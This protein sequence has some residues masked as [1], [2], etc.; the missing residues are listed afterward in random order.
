M[1]I[2]WPFKSLRFRISNDTILKNEGRLQIISYRN[3]TFNE[4]TIKYGAPQRSALGPLL[5]LIYINDLPSFMSKIHTISFAD[6]NT[7]L[8]LYCFIHPININVAQSKP[9][10]WFNVNYL[11]LNGNKTKWYFRITSSFSILKFS[12]GQTPLRLQLNGLKVFSKFIVKSLELNHSFIDLKSASIFFVKLIQFSAS[13]NSG[14]SSAYPMILLWFY[15][16][17]NLFM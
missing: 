12:K 15:N 9:L 4:R 14:R 11:V 13:L 8:S 17:N 10:S 1:Y 16:L 3:R 2:L 6:D 5:F 7:F